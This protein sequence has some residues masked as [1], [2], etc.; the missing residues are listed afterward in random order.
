MAP[1]HERE[2]DGMSGNHYKGRDRGREGNYTIGSYE[3]RVA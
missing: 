2:N 3:S 1:F